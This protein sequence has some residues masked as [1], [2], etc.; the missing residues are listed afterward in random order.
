M[1]VSL[2]TL[3]LW[4][5]GALWSDHDR[6][7]GEAQSHAR[8]TQAR[9]RV[10]LGFDAAAGPWASGEE[11]EGEGAPASAVAPHLLVVLL[12]ALV[13]LAQGGQVDEGDH[14]LEAVDPLLSF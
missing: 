4:I 1:C 14:V 8:H 7:E 10:A 6:V 9:S 3:T 11:S 2:A 5:L 13:I 12:Q